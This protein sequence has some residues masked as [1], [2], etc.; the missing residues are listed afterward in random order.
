M[1]YALRRATRWLS[2]L[3]FLGLVHSLVG[4]AEASNQSIKFFVIIPSYNNSKWCEANLE[5]VFSQT[6]QNWVIYYIDDLSTDDTVATVERYIDTRGMRDKCR[7]IHN[8]TRVGAMENLYNGIHAADPECVIATLDGDDRLAN[9]DVLQHIAE[10]YADPEVWL[11]YGSFQAEPGGW[12]GGCRPIPRDVLVDVGIRYYPFWITSH[13][14][15]FYAAL[16]HKIKKEDLMK[17]GKFVEIAYD[18]AIML[19]MVEMASPNH[20]RY[21]HEINYLYNLTNPI[22]DSNRRDYQVAVERYIR[23]LPRYKPLPF[24]FA[25]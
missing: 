19:P 12:R 18:V 3:C 13:L 9:P 25:E 8:S 23:S 17:D 21:I 15:T 10:V 16:F 14:R 6:Y 5:S 2:F 24:L 11:T 1:F 7:V 4:A 22:S 20:T